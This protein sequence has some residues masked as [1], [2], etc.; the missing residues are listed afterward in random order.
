MSF[1]QLT[2]DEQLLAS[3]Q[4]I[5]QCVA[6]Y[7]CQLPQS[8]KVSETLTKELANYILG[9][10]YENL[11][12]GEIVLAIRFNVL[13]DS[14]LPSGLEIEIVPFTMPYANVSFVAK[15][16]HNYMV[17]RNYLDRKFQN[18]IDGYE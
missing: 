17:I 5:A 1:S 6:V 13:F 4:I 7:G 12:V 18:Q 11:T 15:V 14:R 9:F 10:G 2:K 8:E 3:D 16:L